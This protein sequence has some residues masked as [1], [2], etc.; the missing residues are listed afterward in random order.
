VTI[1]EQQSNPLDY[2]R[3]EPGGEHGGPQTRRAMVSLQDQAV[4]ADAASSMEISL[5]LLWKELTRGVCRVVQSFFTEQRCFVIV[6]ASDPSSAESPTG[7]RLEILE[8]V[9]CGVGQK[10]IAIDLCL[11]PSTVALN[12]RLGLASLGVEGRPSRVHPLLMLAAKASCDHDVAF[13]GGL[14]FVNHEG[15]DLRVIAVP[16]PDRRLAEVL[17]P[18]ELAVVRSLVE[19]TSYQEIAHGRGTSTRT[20]A[21]QITAVFRRMRVSGRNELLLRLFFAEGLGRG[22]LPASLNETLVPPAS[23]STSGVSAR[24]SA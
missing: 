8:S 18:A 16:R 9:L 2:A 7:R 3:R 1:S 13:T 6:A 17:P 23:E 4:A 22:A 12:A 21:N 11:A 19:G 24:R 20:I 10:H 5:A 14:S 15:L